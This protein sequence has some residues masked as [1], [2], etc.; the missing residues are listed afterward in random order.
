MTPVV[1]YELFENFEMGLGVP[2][3]LTNASYDWGIMA[4][5]QYEW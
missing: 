3:G 5:I 4:Q 1:G 2:I